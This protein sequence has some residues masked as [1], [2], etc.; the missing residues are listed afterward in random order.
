MKINGT[1]APEVIFGA[2]ALDPK[3]EV[4]RRVKRQAR[5]L[6]KRRNRQASTDSTGSSSESE[7][8]DSSGGGG[9]RLF[10]EEVRVKKVWKR[11]PG[12]LTLNTLEMMQTAVVTQSGQLWDLDRSSL[13]P[14][15]SQY[16]KL[17]L[18]NK[19]S[20]PLARESQT[21]CYL[22]DLLLQGKVAAACDVAT[23]RLKGLEQIAAGGHYS[24]DQRQELVPAEMHQMTT[25]VET[26]EAT[27]LQREEMKAKT[28]SARPWE[29]KPEWERRAEEPKGKGKGKENKGKSKGKGERTG[30]ANSNKEEKK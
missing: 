13:P 16:W 1:K 6:T 9:A 20:G 24:I 17:A 27:R 11:S 4:R 12:A 5:K 14:I 10:G 8:T 26:L 28:M 15:F 18:Q 29:R 3:P 7:G 25:A 30:Q 22:Q 2:T 23:Q 21:L 19:M